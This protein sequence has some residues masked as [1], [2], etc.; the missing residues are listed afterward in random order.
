MDVNGL[1]MW[2]LAGPD[3]FGLA[4][5]SRNAQHVDALQW[6][7]ERDHLT[8]ASQHDRPALT[9]DEALARLM[10]SRPS[11]VADAAD[12]FAWLN[13]A[14]L[15]IEA[16]GF[17]PG[18]VSLDLGP[19][20]KPEI[21]TPTLAPT[22]MA[23]GAEQMLYIARD[24][25]V[26]LRD[27]RGRYPT[28]RA[29][30]DGFAAHLLAPR[31]G[32][33]AWAFDQTRNRLAVVRGYPL[34]LSG[35]TDAAPDRFVP[36][37]PN[38]DP[39]RIEPFRRS[40]LPAQFEAVALAGSVGGQIALLAWET[41]AEAAI[42]T[43]DGDRFVLRARTAGIRFPWSL[44]WIGEDR[45][46]VIASDQGAVARQAFVY[47]VNL[48]FAEDG[49]LPEGR[50][51]LLR[52]PWQGRFCNRLGEDPAYLTTTD[53]SGPPMAV[54]RLIPLSGVRY[55]RT[56]SVLIG[57]ID[58]GQE[59]T[60]WHRLYLEAA[61][62]GH[63]SM[64]VDFFA[65][66]S[67][68]EPALPGEADAPVWAPHLVSAR[69]QGSDAMAQASWC[70]GASELPATGPLLACPPR[71]GE[72]GLFTV[73][74]QHHGRKVRRVTGRYGW[75]HLTLEG[76]GRDTPELAAIRIYGRRFSYRDTYLPDF[77]TENLTGA[78]AEA[79]GGASP[80]DF[81]DRML[82][83]F[84][85]SLTELEGR[86]A[87][88]WMLTDPASAP[89]DALP[90][91]G[92]W[93]GVGP[94]P[95]ER[96]VLLRER[97]KAAPY[98]AQLHGTIGGLMAELELA[99]G[100]RCI[101]GGIVDGDAPPERFGSLVMARQGDL[102]VRSLLIG[103]DTAGRPA[104]LAGGGVT[105]GDIVIVEGFRMRRTFATILGADLAEENDPLTLGLATSGNSFVGDTLILGEEAVAEL[106]SLF[107]PEI[108]TAQAETDGVAQFFER[109][110]HR[111]LVLVRGVSDAA[112]MKR[113]R[114]VV[115][116]CLPAHI[117]PQ[118]L[119]AHTP[120][121]V[122]AASLVGVD[123]YLANEPPVQRVR[124]NRSV[125]G[126]GDQIMGEGWLDGRADG[127]MALAP[128]AAATGPKNVWRG[129]PFIISGLPSRA[130]RGRTIERYIWTWEQ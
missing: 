32:G 114:D 55:A 49:L 68:A 43:F 102:A 70:H 52:E 85:G 75:I 95:A 66:D 39:P 104:I 62:P 63:S 7:A 46:A 118:V 56:G 47:P 15:G 105:R 13:P 2:L 80:A 44:A 4:P 98:T 88:S 116:E 5:G 89:D 45:V 117:E 69:R 51:Y 76:D 130:A 79:E 97:L 38:K 91:I 48:P 110:A 26:I 59:G 83:L 111:V 12:T 18:M 16:S 107:R 101:F 33:G 119:A 40:A 58:S 42:F 73:L 113:L 11:P 93:I 30:R 61:V 37:D 41:G 9:E 128:I 112:E 77:Y 24:G 92:S 106:L 100:A 74:V 54:R 90:W 17:A 31:P 6:N 29:A 87:G 21:P 78:D 20:N 57:P 67:A 99:T 103:Q 124:I 72:A 23:L 27:L 28:S 36:D 84:E 109:L 53:P 10:L 121:I 50:T 1:P 120:L 129:A 94:R 108:E 14:S 25:A 19:A 22:D 81:L 60:V 125:V 96:A 35:L 123:T 71:E 65:R 126:S 64:R 122:G 115:G 34:R 8:L 127:P 82:G 86:I 3:A